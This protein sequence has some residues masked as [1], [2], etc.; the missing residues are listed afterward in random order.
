M[1]VRSS[2]M[3]NI[4]EMNISRVHHSS[5]SWTHR[6]WKTKRWAII[7][8][9]SP[10]YSFTWYKQP[11]IFRSPP[12]ASLPSVVGNSSCSLRWIVSSSAL[13]IKMN[14]LTS[15]SSRALESLSIF[16]LLNVDKQWQVGMIDECCR[17]SSFNCEDWTLS[18][19]RWMWCL[20]VEASCWM[21]IC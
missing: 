16:E 5:E 7:D 20:V 17:T 15:A 18:L 1:I 14:L 13:A 10:V 6:R 2:M 4:A 19:L 21:V 3:I 11:L 8:D 9:H 12:N